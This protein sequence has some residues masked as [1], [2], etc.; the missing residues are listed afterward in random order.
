MCIKEYGHF[1]TE[2]NDFDF[3]YHEEWE[4]MNEIFS[5]YYKGKM[6]NSK[7]EMF[8]II[9]E[10]EMNDKKNN[11]KTF[12]DGVTTYNDMIK[13]YMRIR[14]LLQR[15]ECDMPDEDF[16]SLK[17]EIGILEE[18]VRKTGIITA[19]SKRAAKEN[20]LRNDRYKGECNA[21]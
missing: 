3:V 15:I 6:K 12:F 13:K 5:V 10:I 1:L 16:S 9:K 17:R 19:Y 2:E 4:R 11:V 18:G 7:L 20:G 14:F 21:R 8:S